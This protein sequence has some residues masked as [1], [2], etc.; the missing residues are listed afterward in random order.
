[1]AGPDP[2]AE[3]LQ[4]IPEDFNAEEHVASCPTYPGLI[5]VDPRIQLEKKKKKI[6]AAKLEKRPPNLTDAEKA[7]RERDRIRKADYRKRI[8]LEKKKTQ[9]KSMI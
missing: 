5:E 8:A 6:S 1:M 2:L 4:D 3:Y 7:R 9:P